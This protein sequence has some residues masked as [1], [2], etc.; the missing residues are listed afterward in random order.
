M[1]IP[2]LNFI[3]L[4]HLQLWSYFIESP[5]ITNEELSSLSVLNFFITKC[6]KSALVIKS[7][8]KKKEGK[9]YKRRLI[10]LPLHF[11]SFHWEEGKSF[12]SQ[13]KKSLY[14]NVAIQAYNW[15]E[16]KHNLALCIEL[17]R[18]FINPILL[19]VFQSSKLPWHSRK[20]GLS[21]RNKMKISV[22]VMF[23]W[24]QNVQMGSCNLWC[25]YPDFILKF[26]LVTSSKIPKP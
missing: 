17:S 6:Y 9:R 8:K 1:N 21:V 11:L 4:Y 19:E 26:L 2:F 22:K 5:R 24:Q 10:V 23:E 14:I 7:I 16:R 20:M 12:F 25:V 13:K 18:L 15:Y 3:E